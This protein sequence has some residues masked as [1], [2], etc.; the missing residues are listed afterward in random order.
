M[1]DARMYPRL[2]PQGDGASGAAVQAA[3]G[4]APLPATPEQILAYLERLLAHP[5]WQGSARRG[6]FLRHIVA[7]TLAGRGRRLKGTSVAVEVFGRLAGGDGTSDA[8]V[9]VEARRLRRDLDS[10]YVGPGRWDPIRI[11][12]PKGGYMAVFEAQPLAPPGW[13]STAA[14]SPPGMADADGPRG[15]SVAPFP[16]APRPAAAPSVDPAQPVV[17][18][19]RFAA[20]GGAAVLRDLADGLTHEVISGLMRHPGFRLHSVEDSFATPPGAGGLVG[21]DG[22][23]FAVRGAVQAEAG[24]LKVSVRLVAA[25]DG[26]VVW[27]RTFTRALTGRDVISVQSEIACDIADALAAPE[28]GLREALVVRI[29]RS[30]APSIESYM[31][32]VAAQTYRRTHLPEAYRDTRAGLERAVRCDP[33]YADAWACLAF[34][35]LDGRRFGHDP[36]GEGRDFA[37]AM[38]AARRA[39]A[40]DPENIPG[41]LALL[42]TQHYAGQGAAALMTG[43]QA[44]ALGPHDPDVLA[45]LGWLRVVGGNDPGGI[46]LLERAVARAVNPPPRYFRS[47]AVHRLMWGR[48]TETLEVAMRAAADGMA[49]SAA[50][51]AAAHGQLG[52]RAQ[53]AEALEAMAQR[54]PA[55]ARDPVAYLMPHRTHPAVVRALV[56]GLR[57]AGWRPQPARP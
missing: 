32:V 3:P 35:R 19:R 42:V 9:R 20:L 51:L 37:P 18:V 53:A 1:D 23:A 41:H 46:D 7:E 50:L 45:A 13:P 26:R 40:L 48:A 22:S 24:R 5:D 36:Q 55:L 56:A 38:A 17:L 12:V 57:Q 47:I 44:I 43:E 30:G 6:A 52:Q 21:A 34:L 28:P 31:A 2:R 33:G 39:L 27:G 25:A 49:V 54:C 8:I 14:P 29:A 10:Y 16:G 15:A 11:G 4:G